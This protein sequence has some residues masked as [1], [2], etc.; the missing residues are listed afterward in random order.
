VGSGI[1]PAFNTNL[2][3]Y[4]LV[5]LATILPFFPDILPDQFVGLFT[6]YIQRLDTL[7]K[8]LQLVIAPNS[9]PKP[10]IDILPHLVV[11]AGLFSTTVFLMRRF[12]GLVGSGSRNTSQSAP[13]KPI[14]GN[15]AIDPYRHED[16]INIKYG[17]NEYQFKYPPNTI[18]THALTVGHVRDKCAEILGVDVSK[19]V[20]TC[21]G[22]QLKDDNST[23]QTLR[24]EHGAKILAM[25]SNV[26]PSQPV[27]HQDSETFTQQHNS[28]ATLPTPPKSLPACPADRIEAVREHV[29]SNLLPLVN[30]FIY[31]SRPEIGQSERDDAHRRLGETI[32]A[33][34]LKLDGV[35][36]EDPAIRARRKQVVKEIQSMLDGLDQ[37]L[38]DYIKQAAHVA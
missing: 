36:T 14:S 10:L 19:L 34:L 24:I 25:G 31:D 22:V 20:L 17:P 9:T 12:L 18:A 30:D 29:V 27:H 1:F 35:E 13:T 23:L 37:A 38:N 33:E 26:P 5:K 6:P 11:F 3:Q 28:Q 4:K 21:A 2:S 8:S 32:M 16:I 7:L 15:N